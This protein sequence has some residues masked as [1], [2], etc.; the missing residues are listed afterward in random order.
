MREAVRGL[1]A[2]LAL[3]AAA[4]VAPAAGAASPAGAKDK[5]FVRSVT[6][7]KGTIAIRD[8][9]IALPHGFRYLDARDAQRTLTFYGHPRHA[10]VRA[11]ILPPRSTVLDALYFIVATYEA[12]GHVSDSDAAKIDYDKMLRSMQGSEKSDN[13]H[14]ARHGF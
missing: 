9:R 11:L 4:V 14:R 12:D 1:A 2:A 6:Y 10:E 3:L 7:R 13:E 8:A 5:A